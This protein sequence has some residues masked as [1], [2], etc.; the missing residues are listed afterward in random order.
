MESGQGVL[1]SPLRENEMG[2]HIETGIERHWREVEEQEQ[3]ERLRWL[4]EASKDV[5]PSYSEL[6]GLSHICEPHPYC[7]Y[8]PFNPLGSILG[9]F[10]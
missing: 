3:A 8:H 1:K 4:V 10:L 9:G 5:Y 7:S 2:D 6:R